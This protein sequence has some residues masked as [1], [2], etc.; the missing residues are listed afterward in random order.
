MARVLIVDDEESILKALWRE[1]FE[2]DF[3]IETASSADS[4][5]KLLEK[6]SFQMVVSDMRMPV[7]D[8]KR[9]LEIVQ[10][11]FPQIARAV[12]SG[13]TDQALIVEVMAKGVATAFIPKPWEKKALV[14]VIQKAL[15]IQE[16]LGEWKL[17]DVVTHI[18]NLPSPPR[19]YHELSRAISQ[20][21]STTAVAAIVEKDAAM[22]T[23]LLH[24]AN[25]AFYSWRKVTS[26]ERAVMMIGMEGTRQIVLHAS[27]LGGMKMTGEEVRALETFSAQSQAVNAFLSRTV[28]IRGCPRPPEALACVGILQDIG[29]ILELQHLSDRIRQV[30]QAMSAPGSG[31]FYDIEMALGL[32]RCTHA[33]IGAYFLKWW[34]LPDQLVEA[35]LFHHSPA[36][37]DAEIRDFLEVLDFLER[38]VERAW[39]LRAEK[40]PDLSEMKREWISV[41]ELK[42]LGTDIRGFLVKQEA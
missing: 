5:L 6:K 39:A 25:S 36:R 3:E 8:G 35:V 24:V 9:F 34:N 31:S 41:K 38:V 14:R 20:G 30:R 22:T 29:K 4:A 16:I 18:D 10:L 17:L 23:R 11:R 40:H 12:L 2:E 33:E 7:M 42:H 32:E 27:V 19:M 28:E 13:F 21:D 37:A 15:D 26:L 1:L